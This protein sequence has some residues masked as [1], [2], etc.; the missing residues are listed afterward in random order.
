[1]EIAL[2]NEPARGDY[3]CYCYLLR[4]DVVQLLANHP[5]YRP[6]LQSLKIG[7]ESHAVTI[8]GKNRLP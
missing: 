1:M 2:S 4:A 7:L 3:D 6:F 5:A 8:W